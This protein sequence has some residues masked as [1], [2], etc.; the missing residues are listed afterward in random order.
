MVTEQFCH[1][2]SLWEATQNGERHVQTFTRTPGWTQKG[3]YVIG[4]R[5]LNRFFA[6]KTTIVQGTLRKRLIVFL[7]MSGELEK[8]TI[9]RTD[10]VV[11]DC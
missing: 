4:Y 1:V 11:V 8:T 7:L 2:R 10:Q 5:H 6:S 3:S 9:G